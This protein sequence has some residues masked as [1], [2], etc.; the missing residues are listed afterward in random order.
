MYSDQDFTF[1]FLS[2][3]SVPTAVKSAPR[4]ACSMPDHMVKGTINSWYGWRRW[5]KVAAT[6]SRP[7]FSALAGVSFTNLW[8]RRIRRQ[9]VLGAHLLQQGRLERTKILKLPHVDR[10]WRSSNHL[11]GVRYIGLHMVDVSKEKPENI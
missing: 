1:V 3:F 2:D 4:N 5:L 9:G 10:T 6:S 7:L 11:E 8:R